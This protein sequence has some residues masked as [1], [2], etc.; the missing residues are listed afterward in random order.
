[1]K[2]ARARLIRIIHRPRVAEGNDGRLNTEVIVRGIVVPGYSY[3]NLDQASLLEAR[4]RERGKAAARRGIL[5]KR[6]RIFARGNYFVPGG[7]PDFRRG[8]FRV[9]F[10]SSSLYLP[11]FFPLVDF[12]TTRSHDRAH[13][14]RDLANNSGIAFHDFRPLYNGGFFA[15]SNPCSGFHRRLFPSRLPG[16]HHRVRSPPVSLTRKS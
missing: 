7:K 14:A 1:M 12:A 13:P 2:P 10:R 3:V 5:R 4:A 6:L 11:L 16:E 8:V 9:L 15:R